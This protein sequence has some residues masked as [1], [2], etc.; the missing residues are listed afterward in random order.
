MNIISRINQIHPTIVCV[1]NNVTIN[2]CANILLACGASPTMSKDIRE[3]GLIVKRAGG[4]VLNLGAVE[5]FDSM[6]AAAKS[7]NE[8]G[9][10]TVFD[11][12]AAGASPLR[13]NCCEKLLS[14]AKISV[15]RGNIS[16]IRALLGENVSAGGVD[17]AQGDLLTDIA[18]RCEMADR[19][20]DKTDS[21]VIISGETDVISNGKSH[22]LV[23]NGCEMMTRITG[24]GCML[25]ALTGAFCAAMSNDI[26][27]AC[28]CSAAAMGFCGEKAFEKVKKRGEGTASFR[29]YLIDEMSLLTDEKLNGGAKIEI[30]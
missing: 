5:Y 19:L 23:K 7:A 27:T 11:P 18:T 13:K 24:S 30:R 10:P 28:A 2:D 25:T 21:V 6:T 20:A 1:T 3:V 14:E 9:I 4:V 16:E 15:I 8:A 26:F 29:N 17:A 22:V 12:V